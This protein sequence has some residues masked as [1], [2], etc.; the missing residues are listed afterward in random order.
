ME[1]TL[2]KNKNFIYKVQKDETLQSIA[3]K[4]KMTESKLIQDNCLS[5]KKL[6]EGDILCILE[7]NTCVY[8]VKPLDTLKKIAKQFNVSE[9][10]IIKKNEL[11][12]SYVFIGQ[13]LI[14]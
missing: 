2:L 13:L 4:F 11:N 8:T 3:N 7:E 10:Y 12:N 1:I 6:E 9:N 5:A 14:I